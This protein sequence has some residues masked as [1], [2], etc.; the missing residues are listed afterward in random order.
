MGK[1]F[2]R[3]L[4]GRRDLVD[5]LFSGMIHGIY[6]GDVWKLSMRSGMFQALWFSV[7]SK[8][9]FPRDVATKVVHVPEEDMHAV[10]YYE[11]QPDA[12][13]VRDMNR[14]MAHGGYIGFHSGFSALTDA[15]VQKLRGNPNVTI[16][17]GKP[18]SSI[19]MAETS[20]V[21][22]GHQVSNQVTLHAY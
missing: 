9:Q 10:R 22:V 16:K 21:S 15:L 6:G 12:K 7:V 18:V 4:G 11:K 5:N 17:T 2:Q 14:E 20:Y 19:S 8:E 13:N 1:F 3:Y